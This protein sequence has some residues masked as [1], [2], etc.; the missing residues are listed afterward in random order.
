M[1]IV[2]ITNYPFDP[3]KT[4]FY[5]SDKGIVVRFDPYQVGSLLMAS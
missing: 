4:G 1:K 3:V 2:S 5:F